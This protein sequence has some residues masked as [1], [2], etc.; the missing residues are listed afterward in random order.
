[1]NIQNCQQI[2]ILVEGQGDT[3]QHA[4]AS[5]LGQIQKKIM[6]ESEVILRIEPIDVDIV[7]AAQKNYTERFFFFFFPR[8]RT[9]YQV[10]LEVLV[11]VT[12]LLVEDVVFTQEQTADPDSIHIP[13]IS[14]KI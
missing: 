7:K 14:K 6:Q 9:S 12:T 5:A 1:M 8:K 11:N 10:T 4:F 3:K 13:V 2:K